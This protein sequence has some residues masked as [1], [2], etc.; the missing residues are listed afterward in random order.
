MLT[1]HSSG[2]PEGKIACHFKDNF[3]SMLELFDFRTVAKPAARQTGMPR[4]HPEEGSP[5]RRG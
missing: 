3:D 5:T 1:P 2:L 4:I